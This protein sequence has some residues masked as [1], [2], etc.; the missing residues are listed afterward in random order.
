MTTLL[1]RLFGSLTRQL[2]RPIARSN[3]KVDV[4]LLWVTVLITAFSLLMIYSASIAYA[5]KEVGSQ[6]GYLS[7]QSMF[8]AAA[9]AA[10]ILVFF[11]GKTR[12]YQKIMPFYFGGCFLLLMGVLILGRSING[13]TRW[14]HAGPINIQPTEFF[15]LAVILYLAGLFIRR[16]EMLE[17]FKLN[18]AWLKQYWAKLLLPMVILGACVGLIMLQPDFGSTVVIMVIT[19]GMLFLT[20]FPLKVLAALFGMLAVGGTLAV[21]TSP[22]RM[23]RIHGFLNPW[24]D[25]WG[26][27]YQ[28]T[29]SL[30]AI[31]RGG[32]LG[33]GLGASLEKRFY[34][35]EAHTDFIF[36]VVAEE[37]GLLGLCL[38]VAA[39]VWIVVRAFSIG[40]QA[41][42][43][44]FSFN[45]NVA[46][47]IGIWIGI[48]SFFNLG[49][50]LGMF[51]TK[52]LP[53]PLMSYGGS[54][55]F[56]MLLTITMLLRIDYE[57]R[58][59]LRGFQVE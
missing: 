45:G 10:C 2:N 42:K 8:V 9:V 15:K 24:E 6:Y 29:H 1:N 12:Y 34:L 17:G 48:Q 49:V 13:A 32:W 28:L 43:L 35:P 7:K 14:I 51:P 21:M 23:A 57:N 16:A 46:Y 54:S 50:N 19:V 58:Q 36:A 41:Q 18:R 38:L 40:T 53:L 22:Y 31:G 27:G 56:M 11:L 26:K 30:M 33:E 44:G 39:Y 47:G 20:R 55:V 52:G 4:A 25:P 5:A 37:F 3:Q 59:K